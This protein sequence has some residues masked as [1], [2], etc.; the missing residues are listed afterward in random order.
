MDAAPRSLESRRQLILRQRP[1]RSRGV[2]QGKLLHSL[3]HEA[4]K[5]VSIGYLAIW[6]KTR[7]L[8]GHQKG[9]ALEKW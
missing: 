4:P 7:T 8:P 6:R 2:Q 9:Y 1:D 3:S 5:P